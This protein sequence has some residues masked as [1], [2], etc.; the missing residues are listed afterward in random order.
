MLNELLKHLKEELDP[1]DIQFENPRSATI[2][3][4]FR[5][6]LSQVW[7]IVGADVDDIPGITDEGRI[8]VLLTSVYMYD[9]LT[10]PDIY[11]AWKQLDPEE[12]KEIIDSLNFF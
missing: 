12:K 3:D 6:M 7:S 2:K 8:D 9:H 5:M 10:D 4:D 1:E 11:T